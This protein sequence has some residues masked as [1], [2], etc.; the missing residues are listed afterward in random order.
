MFYVKLYV[1]SLVDKLN[2]CA[3]E[4]R[5]ERKPRAGHVAHRSKIKHWN[6]VCELE[7]DR[8]TGKKLDTD[9]RKL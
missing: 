4:A 1:H 7:D 2:C 8:A 6:S 3:G 9:A 5:G